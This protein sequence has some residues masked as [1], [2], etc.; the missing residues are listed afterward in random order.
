MGIRDIDYTIYIWNV[1]GEELSWVQGLRS[2]NKTINNAIKLI[3][4]NHLEQSHIMLYDIRT[5]ALC[6]LLLDI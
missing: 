5:L 4:I 6:L 1:S 3:H 2:G